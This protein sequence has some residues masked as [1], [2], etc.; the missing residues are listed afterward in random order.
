LLL[1][2]DCLYPIIQRY[3]TITEGEKFV[4]SIKENHG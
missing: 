3:I 4:W 2:F 1:L